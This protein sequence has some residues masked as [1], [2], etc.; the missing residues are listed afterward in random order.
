VTLTNEENNTT[1]TKKS[2]FLFDSEL[3]FKYTFALKK[4][5]LISPEIRFTYTKYNNQT[6]SDVY[7]NDS[8]SLNASLKNKYEH[9]LFKRPAS[10]IFDLDFT[11]TYKDFNK[12]H[13]KEAYAQSYN[14]TIGEA[15]SYFEVGDSTI[16][17]K[18]KEY[19]GTD[20]SINN[21]TYEINMDQIIA[22]SNQTLLIFM[23]SGTYV[24]NYNNTL[25]NTNAFLTRFDYII[26]GIMPNYTLSLA[27]A[28]TFTDTKAQKDSR[29]TET[30]LNP[31]IDFAREINK[32]LKISLNFDFTD[33]RSKSTSY[34]YKKS[35]TSL[36]LK[37]VF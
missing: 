31:S 18:R 6:D 34:T 29:G 32:K 9:L 26:P 24:N 27:L 20:S 10:R 15:F 23:M 3:Y 19:Q 37:Y 4:K 35:L 22:F 21:Y 12:T 36:E 16:K 33:N 8:Y 7:Q 14:V 5:I 30:S 17:L 13:K 1:Q 28:T 25:T 11:K 2:S